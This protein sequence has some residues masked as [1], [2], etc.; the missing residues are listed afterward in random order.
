MTY[1]VQMLT[2]DG[3]HVAEVVDGRGYV[4]ARCLDLCS[5]DTVADA[6]RILSEHGWHVIRVWETDIL[7]NVDDIA[8]AIARCVRNRSPRPAS[9]EAGP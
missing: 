9:R 1:R 7:R 3:E 5:A 4:W 2:S 8:L 6:L